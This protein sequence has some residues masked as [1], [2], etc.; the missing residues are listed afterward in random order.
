[1]YKKA[2]ATQYEFEDFYLPFGGELN[3]QN[4]WVKLAKMIPWAEAEELY[5][6]QFSKGQG[7]PAKTLRIALGAL[8]IKERCG[9][10]DEETTLQIRE[11]PYLQF[12]IGY[13]E[14]SDAPPFDSSMM[15]H[16][17]KRLS[18]EFLS[19]VNEMIIQSAPKRNTKIGKK[20][21]PGDGDSNRGKLLID[22]TCA[23]A[24]I[25]F[26]TDISLLNEARV[27]LEKIIDLLHAPL[28]SIIKKP[29]TYREA[30]RKTFL[31]AIKKKFKGAKLIRKTIGKQLGYIRRNLGHINVLLEKS[32]LGLLTRTQYKNL[33][34]IAE[35]FRQQLHMHEAKTHRVDARIVSITQP[36]VRPIVRGK[37]SAQIEFGA[38]ISVSLTDG[39]ARIDHFSWENFHEGLL[40]SEHLQ[41]YY[42]KYG[43]FPESVHVDQIY[44][45]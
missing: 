2:I 25:R 22:A 33:L 12:F 29:R 30:A 31:A 32:S 38:K 13:G 4:R 40:L 7:A 18:L 37:A 20:N 10:S 17:R 34:V 19:K 5:R 28:K 23:P 36:H 8:I 43:C 41:L 15:V 24:D 42:N 14:Y 44:R 1:M 21:D 3:G 16:F 39:Y 27:K 11:N 26:P 35:L 6:T 9:F 45:T